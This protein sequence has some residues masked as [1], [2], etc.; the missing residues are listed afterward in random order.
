[1]YAL[2]PEKLFLYSGLRSNQDAMRRVERMLGAIGKTLG[3]VTEFGEGDAV[4]VA[5]DLQAW[6][7]PDDLPGCPVQHRRP[8]VFTQQRFTSAADDAIVAACPEDVPSGHLQRV[9]GYIDPVQDYHAYDSDLTR[10]MVCWPTRD[11]GTMT[12]CSHGCFYCGEGR[13][14]KFLAL[15]MN[16]Q[17]HM[18]QVVGPT[19][20]AMPQQRCFRMMGWGADAISL[21][22][23]YGV[24]QAYLEKLS[25][26]EGRYGYFH[27]NSDHVDWIADVP[28]RDRL[29]GIWSLA[30]EEVAR[31]VEPGS[32]SAAARIEAMRKLGEMGVPFR[33]KL[34]PTV[35]L[36]GWREEYAA[37][38]EQVFSHCRPETI[39]FCCLIWMSLETLK[40]R[41]GDVIDPE[42]LQAAED[43]E[44]EMKGQTHAP[45]PHAT[46]ATLYRRLISEVRKHDTRI[47]VFLSTETRE[48]WA[49]LESEVGQKARFFLCGCNPVQVP[50]PRLHLTEGIGHSTYFDPGTTPEWA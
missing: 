9:L 8:L 3:D 19:I 31:R 1:M 49:E 32:P 22:P 37:L 30:S 36:A 12:G 11:F 27:S 14:G 5:R 28:H 21:E 2:K 46:R 18:E 45:F 34:K 20:E 41:F 35:P 50:G 42:F 44:E 47:P 17:E 15:G 40:E 38:I 23:E 25:Q 24:F 39:G 26:Y 13:F 48:M 4:D 16:V 33:V 29:I 10:N 6:P 7:P 43:A